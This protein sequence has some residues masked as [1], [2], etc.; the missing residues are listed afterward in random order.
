MVAL[1]SGE[2][3]SEDW[4]ENKTFDQ[5]FSS[6]WHLFEQERLIAVDEAKAHGVWSLVQATPTIE[7]STISHAEL[8]RLYNQCA[9]HAFN[10]G[11]VDSG[12]I[13]LRVCET[14]EDFAERSD[15]ASLPDSLRIK[16]HLKRVDVLLKQWAKAQDPDVGAEITAAFQLLARLEWPHEDQDQ[17]ENAAFNAVYWWNQT[18]ALTQ[19]LL[20]QAFDRSDW[21]EAMRLLELLMQMN[22]A[23][24]C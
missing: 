13:A 15:P 21:A 14:L 23:D 7:K 16:W 18:M 6:G 2:N 1:F 19:Q 9:N 11:V 22:Q 17:A 5:A 24:H 4:I 8:V 10:G 3:E 12:S 20:K